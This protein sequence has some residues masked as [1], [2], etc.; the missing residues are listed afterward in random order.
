[1]T[2]LV[3]VNLLINMRRDDDK[4]EGSAIEACLAIAGFVWMSIE[5]FQPC[6]WSKLRS[7]QVWKMLAAIFG[8]EVVLFGILVLAGC[9]LCVIG[10]GTTSSQEKNEQQEFV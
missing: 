1:M 10:L 2:A 8:V 5:L 6:P 3:G 7:F 4:N 9:T